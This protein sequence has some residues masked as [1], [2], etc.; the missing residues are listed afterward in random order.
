MIVDIVRDSKI[1]KILD[2][3]LDEQSTYGLLKS[4][5][6][7]NV[8]RIMDFLVVNEY[9]VRTQEKFPIIKLN[10]NSLKILK[11]EEVVK[12]K[13]QKGSTIKAREKAEKPNYGHRNHSFSDEMFEYLRNLRNQLAEIESVPSYII[14]SNVALQDMCVKRPVT[15]SDFLSVNGVGEN[16]LKQYGRIFTL[17]I[18][19]Y[20]E[21]EKGFYTSDDLEL[22]AKEL[23]NIPLSYSEGSRVLHKSFGKGTVEDLS[24]INDEYMVKIKFD[25]GEEKMFY[26]S[27]CGM[28]LIEE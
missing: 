19:R 2:W 21:Y 20:V 18:G 28:K 9:A 3:G 7:A 1:Q 16:K 24:K 4:Y 27:Y 10:Q 5:T 26:T 23:L 17:A 25:N 14:F 15:L 12:M 8:K 13:V 22:T 6:E 11:G